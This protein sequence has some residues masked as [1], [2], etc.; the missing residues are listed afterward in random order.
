MVVV[1][2]V[3][4]DGRVGWLGPGLLKARHDCDWASMVN[5]NRVMKWWVVEA[6]WV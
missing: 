1:D 2:E 5:V 4:P 3:E 6:K